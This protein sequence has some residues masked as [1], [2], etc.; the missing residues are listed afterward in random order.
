MKKKDIKKA[1]EEGSLY[2]TVIFEV[3]GQPQEHVEKT[4]KSY[5]ETIKTDKELTF[6]EEEFEPAEEVEEG[7]FS[8]VCEAQL[9]VKNLEK[10][11]WLAMNFSPASIEI[12]EPNKLTV[13]QKEM[14]NWLNDLLAKLHEIGMI[15]KADKSEVEGLIRNFNAMTRNAI[16]LALREP[17]TIDTISKQVG[18]KKEHT[19]KF[20]EALIK[21]K[22]ITKEKNKYHV[23]R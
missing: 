3:I 22:K 20:L 2:I 13:G 4:I 23:I 6:I 8:A 16:I 1:V 15:R 5:L 17:A 19:E 12:L 11:T 18:M 14:T 9:L 21:E 10:L 7:L